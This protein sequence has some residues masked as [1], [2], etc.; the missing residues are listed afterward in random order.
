MFEIVPSVLFIS[1]AV[2]IIATVRTITD[3]LLR[4]QLIRSGISAEQMQSML[5]PPL[6]GAD[7]VTAL[8]W[9]IVFVAV[10]LALVLIEFLPFRSTDPVVYGL[11]LISAGAGFLTYVQVTRPRPATRSPTAP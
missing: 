11:V 3:Y 8:K 2:V 4:R 6:P 5:A 10:G 9:G 7:R 1:M